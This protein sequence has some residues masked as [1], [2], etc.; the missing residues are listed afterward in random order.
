MFLIVPIVAALYYVPTLFTFPTLRVTIV[1]LSS[2]ASLT[3]TGYV[4]LSVPSRWSGSSG[5]AGPANPTPLKQYIIYL[6]GGFSLLLALNSFSFVG[7]ADVQEGFYVLCLL[8]FGQYFSVLRRAQAEILPSGTLACY[9][10]HAS[11]A[12]S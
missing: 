5:R 1:S 6:N 9:A 2:I 11:D 8:P 3:M 7:E 4:L 10:R 12:V